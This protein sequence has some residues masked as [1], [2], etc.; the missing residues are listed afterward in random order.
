MK[1]QNTLKTHAITYFFQFVHNLNELTHT[2]AKFPTIAWGF[3]L[4]TIVLGTLLRS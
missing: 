1:Q 2:E 3:S 4:V